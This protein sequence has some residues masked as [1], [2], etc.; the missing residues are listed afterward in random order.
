MNGRTHLRRRCAGA[1]SRQSLLA[2]NSPSLLESGGKIN[3]QM[4]AER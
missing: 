3:E 4:N 1:R 2:R